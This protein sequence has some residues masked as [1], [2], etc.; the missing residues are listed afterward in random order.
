VQHQGVSIPQEDA[1]GIGKPR[2]SQ[3]NVFQPS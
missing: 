1:P 3:S 2:F